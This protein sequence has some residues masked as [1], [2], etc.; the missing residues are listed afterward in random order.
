VGL[1]VTVDVKLKDLA[2]VLE[3]IRVLSLPLDKAASLD[4]SVRE[5]YEELWRAAQG[6]DSE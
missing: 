6:A 4:A 2:D 3:L 5:K 1:Q